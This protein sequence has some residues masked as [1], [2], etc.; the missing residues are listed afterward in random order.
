MFNHSDG[1]TFTGVPADF[2]EVISQKALEV[3]IDIGSDVY[4]AYRELKFN[5]SQYTNGFVLNPSP[6]YDDYTIELIRNMTNLTLSSYLSPGPAKALL[7]KVRSYVDL[8]YTVLVIP[9]SQGNFYTNSAMLGLDV[10]YNDSVGVL[11]VAMPS[12]N[13]ASV[14]VAR[15]LT[16]HRDEIIGGIR[17]LTLNTLEPNIENSIG[18]VEKIIADSL[19]NSPSFHGFDNNYLSGDVIGPAILENSKYILSKLK[20]KK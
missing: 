15:H 7:E 19:P 1:I 14:S 3:A 5:L 16:S 17:F 9:H 8:G 11:H 2:D 6:G 13:Y 20:V 10:S 18:H 12:S 4:E